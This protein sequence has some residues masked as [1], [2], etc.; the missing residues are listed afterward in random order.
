MNFK[1]AIDMVDILLDEAK[2]SVL[3]PAFL[4]AELYQGVCKFQ[5]VKANGDIRNAVATLSKEHGA[6]LPDGI[7]NKP[8]DD[9]KRDKKSHLLT[10]Y[11]LEKK[12]IRCCTIAS[13]TGFTRV[14]GGK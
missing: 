10:F 3:T 8:I 7:E 14:V 13:I 9:I 1:M 5:F 6:L 12:A 11:D 2:A 4:Y